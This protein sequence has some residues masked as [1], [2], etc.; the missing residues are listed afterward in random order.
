MAGGV[1]GSFLAILCI[2]RGYALSIYLAPL[3]LGAYLGEGIFYFTQIA[4]T[5]CI[6]SKLGERSVSFI[7]SKLDHTGA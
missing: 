7:L 3:G 1:F 6:F 4:L 2:E 5:A